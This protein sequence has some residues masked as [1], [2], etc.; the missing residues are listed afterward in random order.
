[1]L[2]VFLLFLTFFL[3]LLLMKLDMHKNRLHKILLLKSSLRSLSNA[4]HIR[5]IIK[6]IMIMIIARITEKVERKHF[7]QGEYVIFS[8]LMLD[9]SSLAKDKFNH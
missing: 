2:Q 8:H 5:M 1:M 3:L 6:V 9:G 4:L 7:S